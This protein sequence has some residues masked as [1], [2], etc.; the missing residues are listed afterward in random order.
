[1]LTHTSRWSHAP[2]NRVVPSRWQ[3]T[4][5]Q[6]RH[7]P[8]PTQASEQLNVEQEARSTRAARPTDLAGDVQGYVISTRSCL[9]RIG[10]AGCSSVARSRA[11][12]ARQEPSAES[13][14]RVSKRAPM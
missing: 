7:A 2:G 10:L 9:F 11:Q 1:M 14:Q 3:A 13:G 8:D 5:D 12:S 4:N 6:V